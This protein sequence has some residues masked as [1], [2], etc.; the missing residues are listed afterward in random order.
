MDYQPSPT[1]SSRPLAQS[2]WFCSEMILPTSLF[3]SG[4]GWLV[5]LLVPVQAM[6]HPLLDF[7]SPMVFF[8]CDSFERIKGSPFDVDVVHHSCTRLE[9]HWL[10]H[11]REWWTMLGTSFNR[12][13]Q[14]TLATTTECGRMKLG[15]IFRA[16]VSSWYFTLLIVRTDPDFWFS[17]WKSINNWMVSSL[18]RR[19][20]VL[21]AQWATKY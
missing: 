15:F 9:N 7:L 18:I 1:M 5:I 16:V 21:V 17:A 13:S 19:E 8:V 20:A 14:E 12:A 2:I 11:E 4:E 10:W 3:S 6:K